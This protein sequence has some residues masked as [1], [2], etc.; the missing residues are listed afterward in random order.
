MLRCASS[1]LAACLAPA[2]TTAGLVGGVCVCVDS[3]CA[4]VY[5]CIWPP[6]AE[7]VL[8]PFRR[9]TFH[10]SCVGWGGG[11]EGARAEVAQA[12]GE[13]CLIGLR[14]VVTRASSAGAAHGKVVGIFMSMGE[15]WT[16]TLTQSRRR[17]VL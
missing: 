16:A 2:A 15:R 11:G 14:P 7:I 9:P 12:E 6:N 3:V 8:A 5:V 13:E 1:W 10:R 17:P 4:C